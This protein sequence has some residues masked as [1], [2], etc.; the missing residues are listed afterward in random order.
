MYEFLVK[1]I[2]LLMGYY[3]IERFRKDKLNLYFETIKKIA[4]FQKEFNTIKGEICTH[5]LENHNL[6]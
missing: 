2:V 6:L 5:V 4:M 1:L 3:E